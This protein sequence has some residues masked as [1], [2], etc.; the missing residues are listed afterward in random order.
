MLEFNIFGLNPVVVFGTDAQKQRWLPPL[1]A[2]TDKACF[3]VTEPNIGLNTTRLKTKA[4][5]HDDHYVV[6]G[7]KTGHF[8]DQR[9]NRLR[10]RGLSSSARVLDVYSCTGGFSVNA[11]AGGARL[12]HSIDISEA[13]IETARRNMA[14]NRDR[15]AVRACRQAYALRIRH[16]APPI[17]AAV[18]RTR[19]PPVLSPT[20][21]H[22]G[23]WDRGGRGRREPLHRLRRVRGHALDGGRDARARRR[24]RCRR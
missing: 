13:A 7:Q 19:L 20:T 9:D 24:G 21:P 3:C 22:G 23:R 4:E 6:S 17:A 18:A 15:P 14:A 16:P 10:V 12:V 11:A 8:L 5:K 2:G 1:I